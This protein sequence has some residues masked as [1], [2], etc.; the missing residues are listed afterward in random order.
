MLMITCVSV[1]TTENDPRNR[2]YK[3]LPVETGVEARLQSIV[4]MIVEVH[5]PRS[6]NYRKTGRN[7]KQP[8]EHHVPLRIKAI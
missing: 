7:R 3:D 6:E 2:E 8:A 4:H 1:H 5:A